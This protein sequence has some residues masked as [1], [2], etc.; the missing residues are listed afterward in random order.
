VNA[1]W[2]VLP[3]VAYLYGAVPYAYVLPR[4]L[5][6]VDVRTVGSG[7]VGATNAA[8]V[9]GWKFFPL[10]FA[11]DLSKGLLP[12]LAGSLAEADGAH[13][14]PALAVAAA[15]A[16]ILGHVFS[17]FL[18]FRG[19][20]AVAAG[21]GAFLVLAPRALLVGVLV[22]AAV[23]GVWRCVSLA[24]TCA[25]LALAASVWLVY[26]GPLG[27]GLYRTGFAMLAAAMVIILHRA[28]IGRLLNGTE[29][30]VSLPWRRGQAEKK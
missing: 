20:K 9:L 11:L 8:R 27:T 3:L 22:W 15:L 12:A 10:V 26:D 16:A 29:P 17:V 19:G 18:R 24:S 14:P 6:G 7:N 2:F 4:L 25:A 30:R 28:N 21:T 23:F 13:S 5:K 1:S